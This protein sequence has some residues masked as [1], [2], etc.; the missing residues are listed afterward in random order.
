MQKTLV[1]ICGPTAVGK[2]ALSIYLAKE[3]NTEIISCDSRQFFKELQIG[4]APPDKKEL[5][6]VPHHFIQH[7]SIFEPYSVGDYERDALKKLT[8]LFQKYNTVMMVG[9]SGLYEKAVTEG[10]DDF[11]EVDSAI[12]DRLNLQFKEEGIEPLQQL[13]KEKDPVFFNKMDLQNHQRLIRALEICIETGK[14]YSSFRKNH[15]KNRP[16]N[17]IKIGLDLNRAVLYENIH[18]RV[19]KMMEKGLLNEAE[20]LYPHK[21]LNALQTVGYREFFRFFNH[22]IDLDFAIEEVKKNTRRFAKRQLTW[23]RRDSKIKWFEP[24]KVNE[25]STYIKSL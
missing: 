12:R 21:E 23:F 3:F 2:T 5:K 11:P 17:T 18:L 8:A 16:F 14:P 6:E 20:R 10:L 19:D 1:S 15:L 25:I 24:D 13:L 9:G 22:E 7:L 4:V